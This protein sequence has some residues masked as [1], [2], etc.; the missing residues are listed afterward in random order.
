MPNDC[1]CDVRIGA[2]EEHIQMFVDSQF[3]FEKLRPKPEG[4]DWYE[5]SCTNWGTKWDRYDYKEKV[6]GDEG[7][8]ISFT[9]AWS[10]PTNLFEYLAETYHDVWIRC[11]WHEEGGY[12]GV[13]VAYWDD[14][15]KKLEVVN[16]SWKDWCIEEEN[17][18]LTKGKVPLSPTPV[19]M[20]EALAEKT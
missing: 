18:R 12:A 13:F 6:V 3:S 7:M 4:V 8:I 15:D 10:P 9:T 20:D 1:W 2:N 11:D 16:T 17:Y 14:E 5:W 19:E